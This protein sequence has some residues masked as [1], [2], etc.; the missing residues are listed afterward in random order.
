[1]KF[2]HLSIRTKIF[3]SII[4]VVLVVFIDT[5]YITFYRSEQAI[6]KQ[7]KEDNLQL[8]SN[9]ILNINNE[10]T[11][12]EKIMDLIAIEIDKDKN[13]EE[14]VEIIK[15]KCSRFYAFFAFDSNGG[16][17]F[18]SDHSKID[19]NPSMVYKSLK[20]GYPEFL[21]LKKSFIFAPSN[22]ALRDY[23]FVF[24]PFIKIGDDENRKNVVIAGAI[25]KDYL[26]REFKDFSNSNPEGSEWIISERGNII[27]GRDKTLI[28]KRL[29]EVQNYFHVNI[30]K[31]H[32]SLLQRKEGAI[33]YE[34]QGKTNLIVYK[35]MENPAWSMILV[36]NNIQGIE[37]LEKF[38]KYLIGIILFNMF[39]AVVLAKL[40]AQGITKPIE[41]LIKEASKLERGDYNLS[42]P[43]HRKDEIGVLA[44]ALKKAIEEIQ[45]RQEAEKNLQFQLLNEHKLAEVGQLVAGLVHNL[46][47][48]LNG[49][50]GFAQLLKMKNS[51]NAEMCDMILSA[52]ENMKNIIKNV[53][54]KTRL[55]QS[56]Q[57]IPVDLNKVLSVEL[58]FLQADMFFKHEVEKFIELDKSLPLIKGVY[59]D[60]SQSF[61]NIIKNALDAMRNTDK[62]KL[63]VKTYFADNYIHVQISDTGEGIPE[64]NIKY[65]FEPYFTTKRYIEEG[66]ESRPAG[67]GL[68]LYMVQELLKKYNAEYDIQSKV[69]EGTTFTIKFPYAKQNNKQV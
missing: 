20:D 21:N 8:L 65:I 31:L 9:W 15:K 42:L 56:T 64:K 53:L 41:G 12:T 36:F 32:E 10:I 47:N 28:G 6:V 25:K 29:Q 4:I 5:F 48:P 44:K 35:H 17:V 69:G 55:E 40:L 57:E 22:S 52:T 34:W 62:K 37:T 30:D 49:I 43:V 51:D 27:W 14:Q 67:T 38:K 18:R 11:Y 3:L 61:S 2:S 59:S 23:V 19:F 24:T 58:D 66:Q 39:F 26:F 63:T 13:L 33:S 16:I 54:S 1:M 7:A 60:F 68:G 46:N 45:R 50:H